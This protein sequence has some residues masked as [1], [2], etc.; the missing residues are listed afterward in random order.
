MTDLGLTTPPPLCLSA[1]TSDQQQIWEQWIEVL[2]CYF[3]AAAIQ[4]GKRR[5]AVLLYVGG[6]ELRTIH[7]TLNDEDETYD[8]TKKLFN[9][10][11]R[12]KRN[13]TFE[14]FK[15]RRLTPHS[16]E[17]A[18]HFI[19]R[20]KSQALMCNFEEY[21]P[22]DAIC[23]Q[24]I[25]KCRDSKLQGRLLSDS[26]L[27]TDTLIQ[28]STTKELVEKYVSQ[29]GNDHGEEV[30]ALNTQQYSRSDSKEQ[31]NAMN[32]Q[33]VRNYQ[34]GRSYQN[35]PSRGFKQQS[36]R[37]AQQAS[38][39]NRSDQTAGN[40]SIYC[41]C[42]GSNNHIAKAPNCPATGKRCDYC[43]RMDHFESVCQSKK[44]GIPRRMNSLCSPKE[45]DELRSL[46][47]L[48]C[49][50]GDEYI[51]SLN[52]STDVIIKVDNQPISFL[53][54]SGSSVDLMDRGSLRKLQKKLNLTVHPSSAKIYP[55]G[56]KSSL[57][58]DGLIYSNIEY[59][60]THHLARIH[61]SSEENSGNILSRKSAIALGL[62]EMKEVIHAIKSDDQLNLLKQEFPRVF[63]G[64]GK[65]KNVQIK[66]NI[67]PAVQPVCQHL[68]RI[69]FHVREK[70]EKRLKTLLEL[71]I[72]EPVDGPTTWV[73]PVIA[74]PKGETIR[75][76]VDMR[77]AN[78]AI[79]RS[80]KPVPTL[81]ELLDDFNGCKVYSKIDLNDGYHQEELHP[82]SRE[83][84]TFITHAGLFRYKRLVQG[85]KSALEEYQYHIDSLFSHQKRIRNISDDILIGGRTQEEHDENLKKCFQ[86]LSDNNL[87][88][89]AEKCKIGVKEISFFGHTISADGIHPTID[90]VEA[91]QAF[92]VPTCQKDV[93]SFLGMINYL[94]R[95]IPN[96]ASET[97][98]LRKLL[99]KDI[100]WRWTE[101]ENSVFEK[102]KK[103]L[104]SDLVVAHYDQSLPTSLI[105]DAS[106]EGLGAILTQKQMDGT[107]KPVYYASRALTVQEK[108]YCQTEREALA[109]VWGCERFHL[110]LF[111]IEFTVLTDHNPLTVIYSPKGKP[112]PRI[113]R[114]GLRLQSYSFNIIHIPGST[115]PADMLS[116]H[117]IPT[118]DQA[119][120]ESEETEMFINAI[121]SYAVPK[122]LTLSEII[123]E[124]NKDETLVKVQ[125]SVATNNWSDNSNML[126]P[127]KQVRNEL[128]TK[129]GIVLKGDRIIIPSALQERTLK[130]AH[131]SHLG[132]VKTKAMLRGK[133]WWPGIDEAVENL[134]ITIYSSII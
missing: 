72:I 37:P 45:D 1:S 15:F 25:E 7:K 128:S 6:E 18:I 39:Y 103:M 59:Q 85:V 101:E 87:T 60:G 84:T 129:G 26:E 123:T 63:K 47:D 81:E 58:L 35:Q 43:G 91:I 66:F 94:T 21:T 34:Q 23:D 22:D 82:E 93:H 75:L 106:P 73:S 110:Y 31:V 77:E 118:D 80:H 13:Y 86:I 64:L 114:W 29:M 48:T 76:V 109:V 102:L 130:L 132:I 124:S 126:K 133:V 27:T 36:F 68:R 11:F 41:Y 119:E 89:N 61:I 33:Q 121:I 120:V 134:I 62:I 70:L 79:L 90:K 5:K 42:C 96:L 98:V 88:V 55:Y 116:I 51:F 14:R 71:D 95:F 10:H 30:D 8:A 56:S 69:P 78:R 54:D 38:R 108:K 104:S 100:P 4:S 49:D 83:I 67:D 32:N 20:L 19:T 12:S 112:S 28:K 113:L 117:P 131:E 40:R 107:L 17:S 97:A 74:V 50:E 24:F 92:P 44:A 111:G 3:T 122:A 46:S 52:N 127:Y 65:L 57:P 9:E 2:E 105:V 53:R 125:Q 99:R 115:N 16:D